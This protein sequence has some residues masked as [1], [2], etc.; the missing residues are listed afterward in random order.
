[1]SPSGSYG[2]G[3]RRTHY[4]CVEARTLVVIC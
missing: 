4:I 3:I 2:R 1:L